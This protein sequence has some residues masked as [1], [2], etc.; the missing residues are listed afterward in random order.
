MEEFRSIGYHVEQHVLELMRAKAM[1]VLVF[2]KE[3][4]SPCESLKWR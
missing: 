3:V 4:L 2:V 1:P